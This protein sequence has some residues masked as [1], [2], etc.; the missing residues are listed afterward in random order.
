MSL[1]RCG[2]VT[3]AEAVITLQS[4]QFQSAYYKSCFVLQEV[5]FPLISL[6][7]GY[8]YNGPSVLRKKFSYCLQ[9]GQQAQKSVFWS[10]PWDCWWAHCSA[11]LA[12]SCRISAVQKFNW[13]E[14]SHNRTINTVKKLFRTVSL[15]S[16]RTP[17]EN[18]Y[19]S[20]WTEVT[21]FYP[22]NKERKPDCLKH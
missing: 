3:F 15:D 20:G 5:P 21:E 17:P 13:C 14:W 11:G 16:S 19:C 2:N 12:L 6:S 1:E 8:F 10:L 4:P 22:K 18:S 9:P 7:L